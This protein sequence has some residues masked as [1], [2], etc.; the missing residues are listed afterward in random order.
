[1]LWI[2]HLKHLSIVFQCNRI[3][4]IHPVILFLGIE[5]LS[6]DKLGDSPLAD[7]FS[8]LAFKEVREGMFGE[9]VQFMITGGS[10]ISEQ[11][12]T[13]FNATPLWPMMIPFWVSRIT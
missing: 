13:F 11:V 8:K 3:D 6:F 9:S 2:A 5:F 10:C 4:I 1:M 12:L 7:R